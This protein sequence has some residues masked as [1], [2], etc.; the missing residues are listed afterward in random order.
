MKCASA[1]LMTAT[2]PR[3][4]QWR[5]RPARSCQRSCGCP[6]RSNRSC[7]ATASTRHGA[8]PAANAGAPAGFSASMT[9]LTS[10]S[11]ST[12]RSWETRRSRSR[13]RNDHDPF[14]ATRETTENTERDLESD[15][16]EPTT[17]A[18]SHQK[19]ISVLTVCS[20]V[21]SF[22]YL[23]RWRAKP[24]GGCPATDS[25][26]GRCRLQPVLQLRRLHRS[27]QETRRSVSR[28]TDSSIYRQ[29]RAGPRTLA[30]VRK[31]SQDRQGHR[32]ASDV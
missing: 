6:R 7:P 29:V 16:H 27:A 23:L 22:M 19:Y 2:F 20:V 3:Q 5:A 1:W 13:R 24:A 32:Q 31:H 14:A 26:E 17:A 18:R 9:A 4:P 25:V 8:S 15:D 11:S 12:T 30:G 28:S 10:P 21:H